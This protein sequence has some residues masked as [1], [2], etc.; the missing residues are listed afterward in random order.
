MEWSIT[1]M[2][3]RQQYQQVVRHLM[4]MTYFYQEGTQP[5]EVVVQRTGGDLTKE[6]VQFDI[7]PNGTLEFFGTPSVLIFQPGRRS[8]S[9]TILAKSDGVP[10]VHK[11]HSQLSGNVNFICVLE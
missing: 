1:D 7:R 9:T 6:E 2:Y 5:V 11:F 8:A 3:N 10:E 4:Y